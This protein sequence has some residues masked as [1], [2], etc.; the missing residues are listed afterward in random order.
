[1]L[2]ARASPDD[3][4]AMMIEMMMDSAARL[5]MAAIQQP[6][7][8]TTDGVPVRPGGEKLGEAEGGRVFKTRVRGRCR[9]AFW[10]RGPGGGNIRGCSE[11]EIGGRAV[12]AGDPLR[13]AEV[14]RRIFTKS[15]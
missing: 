13:T 4:S 6:S 12:G 5:A 11:V 15:F 14:L 1:M 2:M 7:R 9:N 3:R 8:T 10:P